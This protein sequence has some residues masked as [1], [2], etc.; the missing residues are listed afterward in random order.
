MFIWLYTTMRQTS[1][2]NECCCVFVMLT[3]P[4]A[5]SVSRLTSIIPFQHSK[6]VNL[7]RGHRLDSVSTQSVGID[8]FI[9]DLH[10]KMQCDLHKVTILTANQCHLTNVFSLLFLPLIL[11]NTILNK[12]ASSCLQE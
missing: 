12:S 8:Q 2:G 9:S 5:V 3:N 7:T 11:S 6:T 1:W 10:G 4:A